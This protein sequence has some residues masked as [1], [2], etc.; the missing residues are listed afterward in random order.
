VRSP[1][2]TSRAVASSQL[3]AVDVV[4][5]TVQWTVLAP[6]FEQGAASFASD[7]VDRI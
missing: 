1:S 2:L 4:V 6:A 5:V 7:A 3:G